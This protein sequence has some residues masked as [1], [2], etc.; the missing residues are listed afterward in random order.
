VSHRP[1]PSLTNFLLAHIAEDQTIAQAA[2][3]DVEPE[4]ELWR[5]YAISDN[6]YPSVEAHVEKW[7]P[8]RVLAECETKRRI[9]ELHQPSAEFGCCEGCSLYTDEHGNHGPCRTLRLL[10][11]PYA[12]EQFQPEWRL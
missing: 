10:A 6:A 5:S 8:T 2:L 4:A 7:T 11:L 3:N 1:E 9:V 12:D